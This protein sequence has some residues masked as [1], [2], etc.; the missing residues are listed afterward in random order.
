M[1]QDLLNLK[2]VDKL[3]KKQQASI[4]GGKA[5]CVE[6]QMYYDEDQGTWFRGCCVDWLV[7]DANTAPLAGHK[8]E[9]VERPV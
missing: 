6:Y 2:E 9:C 1:L 4:I 8:T 5:T 7:G 3:S